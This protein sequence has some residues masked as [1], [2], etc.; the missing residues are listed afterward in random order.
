MSVARQ[1][2]TTAGRAPTG[3]TRLVP[4]ESTVSSGPAVSIS[5]MLLGVVTILVAGWGA[6]APFAG[7]DFGFV[8]DRT[9]AWTWSSTSALL[10]LAPG[11]LAFLCGLWVVGASARPSFR[12]RPDLWLMGLLIALSG[13]WF[14]VGQFVWPVIESK[15]FI[16]PSGATHF[17]WKELAFA[18]GPGVILVFC[19]AT[20]MGWAVRRQLAVVAEHGPRGVA[21]APAASRGVGPAGRAAPAA[22]AGV[23]TERAMPRT[24]RTTTAGRTGTAGQTGT[25]GRTGTATGVVNRSATTTGAVERPATGGGAARTSSERPVVERPARTTSPA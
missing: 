4:A 16:V 7:P 1:Y 25:A 3:P 10:A 19:G 18:V 17:M 24:G 15:L 6:A 5:V 20:F 14:V 12:R 23:A 2:T 8:A 22:A 9:T 11:A 13:A 21:P